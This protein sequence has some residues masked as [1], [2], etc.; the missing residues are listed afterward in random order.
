MEAR[1]REINDALEKL[2]ELT[3]VEFERFGGYEKLSMR[4]LVIQL[5]EATAS[6]CIHVLSRA[7][8]EVAEAYPHCFVRLAERRV[9][10]RALAERLASAARLRNLLV[11]RYWEIDDQE[12]YRAIKGGLKDFEEFVKQVRKVVEKA[13]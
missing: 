5:V 7:F 11:H 2:R 6:V 1:V 4:Y 8:E 13:T 12:V 9:I 10:P 3:D